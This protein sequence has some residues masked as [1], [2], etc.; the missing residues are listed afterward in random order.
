MII[1]GMLVAEAIERLPREDFCRFFVGGLC[2]RAEFGHLVAAG[3]AD[4]S[5][6]EREMVMRTLRHFMPSDA[7]LSDD[8]LNTVAQTIASRSVE[9]R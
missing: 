9:L 3:A 5:E 8:G 2:Q 6:K 4:L 1:A 7:T